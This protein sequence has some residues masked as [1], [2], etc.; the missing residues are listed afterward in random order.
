[1][2]LGTRISS[3]LRSGCLEMSS[4]LTAGFDA[5]Q[6]SGE[7]L[8]S[9]PCGRAG[10]PGLL[11]DPVPGITRPP[12]GSTARSW[13]CPRPRVL[14]LQLYAATRRPSWWGASAQNVSLDFTQDGKAISVPLVRLANPD[15]HC[16]DPQREAGI[17]CS[18][19]LLYRMKV[20]A[21]LRITAC[22]TPDIARTQALMTGQLQGVD[23]LMVS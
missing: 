12:S 10:G 8:G 18:N 13:S 23:W 21:P 1:M 14:N 3:G 19:F 15:L 20:I 9:C 7:K 16:T 4:G 6:T 5:R 11:L 22:V 17:C 2:G